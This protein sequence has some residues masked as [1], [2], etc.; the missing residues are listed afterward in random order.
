MARRFT[1][2]VGRT[3]TR[4]VNDVVAHF[5]KIAA[6]SNSDGAP[7]HPFS[8]V[9]AV[10]RCVQFIAQ[11]CASLPLMISTIDDRILESGPVIDLLDGPNDRMSA[12]DFVIQTIGWRELT[13]RV[14]W[15]FT[16][17][18]GVR[19]TEIVVA[20]APQM[21]PIFPAG[22]TSGHEIGWKFRP[23]GMRW[24]EAIT[25]D[26][27]EVWTMRVEGFDPDAPWD[28]IA[29]VDVV[30]KAIAQVYRADVANLASLS[31]GMEPGGAIKTAQ[32]LTED[33]KRDLRQFI[34]EH[35][36]GETNRRRLLL[37]EGGMEFQAMQSLFKDMEFST[38]KTMSRAD[39]CAGFGLDPAAIGYPPEG[40]RFE[41]A[42]AAK[43]DAWISRI[44][45]TAAWLAGQ[46]DRGILR[47]FNN[48]R[49]LS[50]HDAVKSAQPRARKFARGFVCRAPRPARRSA[51]YA[52][53]DASAVPAVVERDK[54][55]FET[56]EKMVRVMKSTPAEANDRLD[57]GLEENDAQKLVWVS[58]T[59][60]PWDGSP[61]G[62]DAPTGDELIEPA[63]ETQEPQEPQEPEDQKNIEQVRRE[64]SQ[65][66]LA[67]IWQSWWR[68]WAPLRGRMESV[69]SR[70]FNALRAEVL[71]NVERLKPG[72][73]VV[74]GPND[75]SSELSVTLDVPIVN[76]AYQVIKTDRRTFTLPSAQCR[77]MIGELLF[78][79]IDAKDQLRALVRPLIRT[80]TQLGG[81]QSMSE[82]AAAEGKDQPDPF[83]INDPAA[84]EAMRSREIKVTNIDDTLRRRLTA[85]LTE[86][87]ANGDTTAEIAERVR[88]EFNFSGARSK[89]IARTEIGGAVENARSLGRDQAK[90][91]SKSWLW[92]RR[93]TGRPWHMEA[94]Q[95]TLDKPIPNSHDFI[96]PQTGAS[97][98][99]PRG[100]GLT[101]ADAV[102]CG[103]TAISRY[104]NDQVKD[105]R[106]IRHLKSS[107]FASRVIAKDE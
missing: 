63:D 47:R 25:L 8:K 1:G 19:P 65:A 104:P 30:R 17:T 66:T 100:P 74:E 83:S 15:I 29:T 13:G 81:E 90:V 73:P 71:A 93:E 32:N 42:K 36:E 59:E 60:M 97:T 67:T 38:L 77:D 107:G 48:D 99:Y 69:V 16:N 89:T 51:L 50:M 98:P 80:S 23:A 7:S 61:P 53:F 75:Q 101:A 49:S 35:H 86:G 78:D 57:L 11:N 79:I 5:A 64:L 68:S 31:N 10:F 103:C 45:P 12:E 55:N 40:G 28:G 91:P 52:W 4:S 14:H 33:Q 88:R 41:Y 70:H 85:Q 82:A 105:L 94:E 27:D 102:N 3:A 46:I 58:T 37:L 87:L 2:S 26:A 76:E 95:I 72:T 6:S 24:D 84:V 22:R 106:I 9:V 56:A 54:S 21:K 43:D 92:S 39:I 20:G 62:S 44:L 96:L 18:S 34:A